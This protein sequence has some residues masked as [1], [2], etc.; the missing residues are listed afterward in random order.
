[1]NWIH[2]VQE[3]NGES[4]FE[5][6]NEYMVSIMGKE[7]DFVRDYLVFSQ[8]GLC[9]IELVSY[10]STSRRAEGVWLLYTLAWAHHFHM[11][12]MIN[13]I[14]ITLNYAGNIT[15]KQKMPDTDR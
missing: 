11:I 4:S 14:T 6:D 1:M 8:G 7:F 12:K 2:A 9:S 10:V 3:G 5:H 13:I 15:A